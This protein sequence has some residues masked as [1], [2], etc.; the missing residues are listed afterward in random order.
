M[1]YTVY[2]VYNNAKPMKI[3]DFSC[4]LTGRLCLLTIR[5]SGGTVLLPS[6]LGKQVQGQNE[7]FLPVSQT[8]TA[9][10]YNWPYP[11]V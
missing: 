8:Q 5:V 1:T 6:F 7:F 3:N 9:R 10:K 11:K 4:R 2:Q